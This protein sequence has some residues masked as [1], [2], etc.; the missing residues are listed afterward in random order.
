MGELSPGSTGRRWIP[1]GGEQRHRE[2]IHKESKFADDHKKLPFNFSKPPKNSP[3]RTFRCL[4]CGAI[5]TAPKNTI[6]IVC[7]ECKNACK[8]E[9]IDE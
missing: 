4:G 2:K 1:E 8:V 9:L 3:N 6:M 7:K 5:T